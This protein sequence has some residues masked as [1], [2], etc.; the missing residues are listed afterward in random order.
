MGNE[1]EKVHVTCRHDLS[2][3]NDNLA[4]GWVSSQY[5]PSDTARALYVN[6]Y[7]GIVHARGEMDTNIFDSRPSAKTRRSGHVNKGYSFGW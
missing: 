6:T 4:E 2:S 5:R 1:K 3:P 7:V